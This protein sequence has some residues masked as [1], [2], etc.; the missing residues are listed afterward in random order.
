MNDIII[1]PIDEHK[2]TLILLH[3]MY[4]NPNDLLDISK[5]LK[6]TFNFLKIILVHSPI[7][8][9]DWPDGKEC[10]V[11]SWYNYYTRNDNLMEHDNI[12][13][14][15]FKEQ[16]LRIDKIIKNENR[17][18]KNNVILGGYSQGGT[19]VYDI[20]LNSNNLIKAGFIFHSVFMDNIIQI[21]NIKNIKIPIF[22]VSG[23][24]DN[25]YNFK[26]Q[27]QMINLLKSTNVPIYWKILNNIGH[28]E[29]SN[30]EEIFFKK[31]LQLIFNT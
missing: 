27:E 25:I 6:N 21:N 2:Y 31:S 20:V 15:Q 3:G 19:L 16:Y 11:N 14:I 12:N 13:K 26:L 23:K 17:L 30:D 1:N 22:I 8:D 5:I 9:I 28:C 4:S 24:K 18:I 10:N 29:Y 7:I